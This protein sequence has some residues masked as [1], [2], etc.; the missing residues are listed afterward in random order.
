[1][2]AHKSGRN[3]AKNDRGSD[4][5]KR[6]IRKTERTKTPEVAGIKYWIYG[7]HSVI[8]ALENTQ[9]QKLRLVATESAARS[10]SDKYQ[11][12]NKI[13]IVAKSALEDLLPIGAVHQ[14]MALLTKAVPQKSIADIVKTASRQESALLVALDQ[15]TDPNNIGNVVRSSAAFGVCA[16]VTPDRHTPQAG[17][18]LAKAASG[19]LETVPLIRTPNLVRTLEELKDEGFWVVG[20]DVNAPSNISESALPAKC[21][22]TLGSE[23]KG[24]RRLTKKTCDVLVSIT[25]SQAMQSI[26]I[27][28]SAAVALYEWRRQ[29]NG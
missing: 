23:G 12:T 15:V 7:T 11:H 27:S 20:L 8:A 1:M 26:N 17:G 16:V 13:E 25:T 6:V 10:I 2:A 24:L 21:V 5:K 14:G 22:L 29:D 3:Y 28:A 9:R 4:S 19:A 18:A